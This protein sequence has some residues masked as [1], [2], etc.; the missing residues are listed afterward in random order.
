MVKLWIV[1]FRVPEIKSGSGSSS[2]GLVVALQH[3][4]N[5]SAENKHF[6]EI[7]FC[8]FSGTP[9]ER[10]SNKFKVEKSKESNT[11]RYLLPISES[12]HDKVYKKYLSVIW[13]LA[14]GLTDKI[15]PNALIN[16]KDYMDLNS[17]L[18]RAMA[19]KI[20][21]DDIIWVQD[22]QLYPLGAALRRQGIEN[23]IGHFS[24]IPKE[25][26]E[27]FFRLNDDMRRHLEKHE[28]IINEGMRAYNLVG[29]QRGC[30]L[31]AF[32]EHSNR[33][34]LPPQKFSPVHIN[35]AGTSLKLGVYPASIDV[36]HDSQIAAQPL[37]KEEAAIIDTLPENV[38]RIVCA[39]RRDISK[40]FPEFYNDITAVLRDESF[41][42]KLRITQE[43]GDVLPVQAY[44]IATKTREGTFGYDEEW[45]SIQEAHARLITQ[46]GEQAGVLNGDGLS[47]DTLL[48][49]YR[50]SIGYFPSRRDGW[51]LGVAEQQVSQNPYAPNPVIV[52]REAGAAD[53]M[54]G[55]L[56]VDPDD[57]TS[58]EIAL[59][60][61]LSMSKDEAANRHAANMNV[62]RQQT[63]THQANIF[64]EHLIAA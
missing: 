58:C 35:I 33:Y 62:I 8:G 19:P 34:V 56:I 59:K 29:F 20:G 54:P 10:A 37:T 15:D 7:A 41:V 60:R 18:A 63:S 2:G 17:R 31:A 23:K 21:P 45:Q 44:G 51:L 16:F 24:H 38:K 55:A 5:A 3:F 48:R 22:Y 40:G 25:R 50:G 11:E 46:F 12:E 14:H 30:D 43:M 39:G 32:A 52:S 13:A 26:R 57:R 49:L 1:S 6:D 27:D 28:Q 61:A 9:A 42:A 64:I 36:L 47:R 53:S 4:F